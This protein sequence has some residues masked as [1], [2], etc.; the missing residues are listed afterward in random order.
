MKCYSCDQQF[1]IKTD[2]ANRTYDYAEGLR[3]HE[4][5]YEPDYQQDNVI[6]LLT[7]EEKLLLE[8]DPMYHLQYH[9]EEERHAKSQRESLLDLQQLQEETFKK[10]FDRNSELRKLNR[11]AKKQKEIQLEEGRK[12]G[13]ANIPMISDKELKEEDY[14]EIKKFQLE[15]ELIV[16]PSSSSSLSSSIIN[17]SVPRIFS[18][19]KPNEIFSESIFSTPKKDSKHSHKNKSHHKEMKALSPQ[20]QLSTNQNS[21]EQPPATSTQKKRKIIEISSLQSQ[22]PLV[23]N[24]L[25]NNSLSSSSSLKKMKP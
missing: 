8:K 17:D 24:F 4:Q 13:F 19:K 5:D 6:K 3:K 16:F 12:R 22:N 21:S 10:D 9:Q 7:E 1:V 20:E 11:L 15:K 2:P 18:T 14:L 23:N 25:G